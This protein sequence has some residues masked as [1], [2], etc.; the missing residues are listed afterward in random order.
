MVYPLG[1]LMAFF[2]DRALIGPFFIKRQG[3]IIR[4]SLHGYKSVGD[5]PPRK[6]YLLNSTAMCYMIKLFSDQIGVNARNS[7]NLASHHS[8]TS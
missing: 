2:F 7:L 3:M 6:A 5:E 8:F 1:E 4:P